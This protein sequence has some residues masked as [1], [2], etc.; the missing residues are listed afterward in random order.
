MHRS[1]VIDLNDLGYYKFDRDAFNWLNDVFRP[2]KGA[3]V[4][5]N[6]VDSKNKQDPDVI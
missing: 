6:N 4:H 5:M 3:V 1:K 2:Q